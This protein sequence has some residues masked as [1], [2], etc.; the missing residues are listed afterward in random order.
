MTLLAKD[1]RT[2]RQRLQAATRKMVTLATNYY[3]PTLP[4]NEKE[5]LILVRR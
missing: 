3:L 2:K 5:F 4:R 1:P